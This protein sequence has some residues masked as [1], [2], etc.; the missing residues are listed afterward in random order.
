MLTRRQLLQLGAS[1]LALPASS[2]LAEKQTPAQS[3]TTLP[4]IQRP[5][6]SSGERLPVIG[7]GTSRTFDADSSPETLAQ[8]SAVIEAFFAGKGSVIDSSPMYGTAESRVGD[9]LK[10]MKDHPKVFA[11]TKVWTTGK[12]QGIAEMEES[13]RR[14]NVKHFDLIAVHNLVDWKTQLNTLKAWKKEGK[15]RYIGITTSH[16][17]DHDEFLDVMRT[18][19]IDFVQFTY[20]IANLTAEDRILPLAQDKGIATMINRPYQRGSLFKKSKGKDLPSLAND[21]D[22]TSWGQFYLKFILGHPAITTVIPAT[23]KARHMVDNMQAN[24]GR[25]PDKQQRAEMLR[26]FNSL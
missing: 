4:L 8:L 6:P 16:G 24:F 18:E 10:Q 1:T 22:C 5:I 25:L 9:V 7:M 21:I 13:A 20:N 19:P 26:I 11:A 3:T 23:S 14:M 15:V 2:L 12:E 17:R